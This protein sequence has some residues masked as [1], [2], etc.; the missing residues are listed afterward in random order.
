MKNN[1]D[2]A[3]IC[4][5]PLYRELL[6]RRRRMRIALSGIMFAGFGL[7]LGIWAWW[8]GVMNTFLPAGSA[9]SVGIW[10]TVLVVVLASVL[11]GY[12]VLRASPRTDR[13]SE[14]LLEELGIEAGEAPDDDA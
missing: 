10:A 12:Y 2:I 14:R 5:S 8:P 13:L 9:V 7:Y 11:S 4:D 3:R 6:R 1:D